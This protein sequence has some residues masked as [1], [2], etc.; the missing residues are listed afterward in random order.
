VIKRQEH[1]TEGFQI[2][3][4]IPVLALVSNAILI[5]AASRESHFLAAGFIAAG[6]ILV[7][8]HQSLE[9]RIKRA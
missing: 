7:V 2:P 4:L 1:P 8:I 6:L 9:K 3:S 5:G